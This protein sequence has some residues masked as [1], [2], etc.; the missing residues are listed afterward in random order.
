MYYLGVDL[1]GTNVAAGIVDET[2]KFLIKES[3]PTR[4]NRKQEEIVKDIAALCKK[5]IS[6]SGVKPGYIGIGSPGTCDTVNGVVVYAN[7]LNFK[8]VPI[9]QMMNRYI[10]LPIYLGNDANCAAIGESMV[11]VGRGYS[12]SLFITL[13]TGVGGGIILNNQLVTGSFFNGG[14]L[15]HT[16]IKFDGEKC[17]CGRYGC[18]EAYASATALIRE[19]KIAA[20]KNQNSLINELSN[21]DITSITAKTAFDA[22]KKNDITATNVVNEYIKHLA[23][24]LVNFV[25]IF[26]PEIIIIG[27]GVSAQGNFLIEPLKKLVSQESYGESLKTKIEIALLGND[28]GIIGAAFLNK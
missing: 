27:G 19:T 14:E 15:G 25:N 8:N 7:N 3:I 5:L 18:L 28:A 10:D 1:G 6:A 2:G 23:I 9:R 17:S 4:G 11:G 12:S 20:V 22:M 24:G 26:E 16:V 13:G 21:N